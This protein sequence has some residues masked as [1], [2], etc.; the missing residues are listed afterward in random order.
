MA[1]FYIGLNRGTQNMAEQYNLTTGTSTGSTDIELRIDETKGW[2]RKEIMEVFK[3]FRAYLINGQ[4][5]LGG[6][7]VIQP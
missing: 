1:S 5:N 4:P 2:T 6:N 7:T 3:V